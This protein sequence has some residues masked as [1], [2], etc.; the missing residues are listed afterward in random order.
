MKRPGYFPNL[1]ALC[2]LAALLPLTV[3]SG[4][5]CPF[6]DTGGVNYWPSGRIPFVFHPGFTNTGRAAVRE[7]AKDW[8]KSGGAVAFVEYPYP[9]A[10]GGP[11][12]EIQAA[13]PADSNHSEVGPGTPTITTLHPNIAVGSLSHVL[14]ELGHAIV[15]HH[16]QS[17]PDRDSYVRV[18]TNHID[19]ASFTANFTVDPWPCWP[20]GTILT[21]YD[22]SSIMHYDW[23]L[24]SV[25][26]C[27]TNAIK[28]VTDTML[29]VDTSVQY[30]VMGDWVG[31]EQATLSAP[32]RVRIQRVYGKAIWV[33]VSSPCLFDNGG[34]NC[35]FPATAGPY[36][37]LLDAIAAVPTPSDP[38][39][40][41]MI[42]TGT[43]THPPGQT[44]RID[45]PMKLV[46]WEITARIE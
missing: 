6:P 36:K 22:Y 19:P 25:T 43:Y 12:V 26:G 17:R 33:D 21:P 9:Y 4:Q 13:L 8:M 18:Q 20:P 14:H 31:N 35:D 28:G 38:P 3:A 39:T 11:Y 37:S 34:F 16:E 10:G 41:L 46:A 32:D 29:A 5:T 40:T 27:G 23:C 7:A 24:G 42:K 15:Y 1:L 2:V 45:K 44:L 30:S